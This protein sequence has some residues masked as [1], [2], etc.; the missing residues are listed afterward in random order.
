MRLTNFVNCLIPIRDLK[1]LLH[2]HQE[3]WYLI[4][5]NKSNVRSV[6]NFWS[7]FT[8]TVT[9]HLMNLCSGLTGLNSPILLNFRA[10]VHTSSLS[11]FF[12]SDLTMNKYIPS[13]TA[14]EKD[15]SK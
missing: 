3:Q 4:Q 15:I 5:I 12:H 14:T 9:V 1:D 7:L 13:P 8:K 10:N 2:F 6:S 11:H